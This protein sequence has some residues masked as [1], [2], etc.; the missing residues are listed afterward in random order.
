MQGTRIGKT[1]IDWKGLSSFLIITFIITYAVEGAL[2][3]SGFRIAAEV[4]SLGQ[5]VILLVMWVP[6]LATILTAGLMC[7]WLGEK[8]KALAAYR[9]YLDAYPEGSK[10]SEAKA[11]IKKLEG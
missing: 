1:A 2:I 9:K 6:A 5:Y 8:D 10:S 11:A 7:D 3:L 4:K